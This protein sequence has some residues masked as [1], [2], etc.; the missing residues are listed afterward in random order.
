MMGL[1]NGVSID[2][3][4]STLFRTP[5]RAFFLHDDFRVNR[6]LR[7][8]LGLRYERE[9]G[10]TERF[11]RAIAAVFLPDLKLPFT[12]AVKAA[13]TANP[14]PQLPAA[15]FNPVGGK[16]YLGQ[17]GFNAAT[18]GTHILLPKTGVVYRFND[19]TVLRAGWGM[20]MDTLNNNNTRP[21]VFGY[22]IGR[23]HV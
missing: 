13:Y 9:G 8:S 4:D 18:K 7:L 17:N 10:I 5:R 20:Y 22:K 11:N 3:N 14:V 12:D 21:D 1:P 19:K 15:Q 16:T 6:K 2:T 23:A